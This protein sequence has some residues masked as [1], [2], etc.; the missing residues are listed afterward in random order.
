MKEKE[1]ENILAR[2]PELIETGLILE[3]RQVAVKRKFID[4][5][6]RDRH[7]GRLIVELKR[8]TILRKD[9]GQ[10]MDYEGELLFPDDPTVRVML[11]GNRVP[12]E[13]APISVPLLSRKFRLFRGDSY[14]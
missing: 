2:Y 7:G 13:A 11:I 10:V 8:G 4:L 14:P 9:I 1:F 5:L 6:F 12:P 3:G